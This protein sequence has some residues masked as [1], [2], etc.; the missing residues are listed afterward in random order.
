MPHHTQQKKQQSGWGILM[1]SAYRMAAWADAEL[2]QKAKQHG[3]DTDFSTECVFGSVL[4]PRAPSV[5][6][7]VSFTWK[8]RTNSGKEIPAVSCRS[9]SIRRKMF[10]MCSDIRSTSDGDAFLLCSSHVLPRRSP[11]FSLIQPRESSAGDISPSPSASIFMN[12]SVWK[13]LR[14]FQIF[15]PTSMCA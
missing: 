1:L 9:A 8:Y 2:V 3:L 7:D 15:N 14:G 13:G 6:R 11:M 4:S 12:R 5:G 10:C